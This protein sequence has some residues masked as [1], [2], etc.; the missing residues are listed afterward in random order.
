MQCPQCQ[1]ENREGRRFCAKC[2]A[3]LAVACPA[4]G[5]VNEPDEDFCGG[6]GKSISPT[7]HKDAINTQ[8]AQL[9][10]EQDLLRTVSRREAQEAERRQLTVM[11]CD[12]VGSTALST[13][14][15]PEDLRE[16]IT[17]FQN[18]CRQ[19][20]KPYE[21]FIARYMGDGMLVYFGYP[22]AHEDD[23][24][25]AVRA[26]IDIVRSMSGLNAE[27]GKQHKVELAVRIG[28]ATGSVVVGD[29]VGEGA[30]EEAAVVGETPNLAARL[31]SLAKPNQVV[32]ASTTQRLLGALFEY[33]DLG[34]R[35]LKGIAQPEQLWR[36]VRESDIENRYEAKRVRGE[37]PLVGRQEELGLLLRSWEASK[38]GGGQVVLIQGEAGVG[39]SRLIEALR[40]QVGQEA[41]LWVTNRCSPYHANSTLYPVIEHVKR[42]IGWKRNDNTMEKLRKLETAL[43]NQSLPLEEAV[44]LYAELLSLPLPEDRYAP[45]ALSAK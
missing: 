15:D 45:L 39:K 41:H 28:V 27:N 21:G 17:S 12:L 26:A 35:K 38:K 18:C 4:C 11:F 42:V 23:A 25:R 33:E 7:V 36:V 14:L 40:E 44:P 37:L 43:S 19:A 32:V 3:P 30:A 22:Q 9:E 5:F 13:R 2:G 16:L 8:A 1:A 24:E 6:C 20:I 29:I 34:T 31:Q 10:P